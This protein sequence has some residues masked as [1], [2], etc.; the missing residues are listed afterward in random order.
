MTPVFDREEK[1]AQ[2][3]RAAVKI[4]ATRGIARARMAEVAEAAGVGKGTIYE[5]FRSKDELFEYAVNRFF[6][7]M[8][9]ELEARLS[10]ADDPVHALEVLIRTTFDTIRASGDEMHIMFEIW[11]EGVRSGV[12]YFDLKKMYAD[13][14]ELISGIISGGLDAGVFRR[15]DPE[16]T[17]AAIIGAL[18]GLLL[19]WILFEEG[20]DLE[21][22]SRA[23][24]DLV[25]N[26]LSA[27]GET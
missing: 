6:D 23:F 7:G 17:A 19:Q 21:S 5:Y 24:I 27:R 10:E 14:R 3:A 12:E 13:Y 1:K 15:V 20:F 2:I 25:M 26:G 11:A 22:A 18:D 8:G 9:A 16:M 4:F